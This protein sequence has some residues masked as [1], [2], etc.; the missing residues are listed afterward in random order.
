MT[1]EGYQFARMETFSAQGAPGKAA[2]G[3]KLRKSGARAWTA[4]EVFDEAE[5]VP[6]ACPH[7]EPGG[8][9]PEII[10]GSVNSFAAARSEHAKA[11]AVRESYV[12]KGKKAK[13]KLRSDAHSLY[14]SVVSLPTLTADALADPELRAEC[15]TLLKD[16]MAHERKAI[17][18]AGGVLLMGVIHWDEDHVHAHYLAIQ[19]RKGRIDELHPGRT[20]KAAFNEAHAAEKA[21][22]PKAVGKGAN[23]AYRAA[24]RRWQDDFYEAV[25]DPAG[26]LRFGPKRLRYTRAEYKQAMAVK[27]LV[28]RGK[29][30]LRVFGAQIVMG[31]VPSEMA[32]YMRILE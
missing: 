12:R 30:S 20:A 32:S 1:I 7:V 27:A 26:L 21:T 25:F 14:S 10:P 17:V 23:A 15:V 22:D 13:R 3:P 31:V 16:A 28:L 5:R 29:L 2:Q 4:T 8:P 18:A 11:A 24:M 9:P 6:L 19:P